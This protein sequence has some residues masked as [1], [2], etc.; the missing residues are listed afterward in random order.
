MGEYVNVL[1]GMMLIYHQRERNEAEETPV[2]WF[3]DSHPEDNK[4]QVKAELITRVHISTFSSVY[5]ETYQVGWTTIKI[6]GTCETTHAIAILAKPELHTTLGPLFM[7][8][9]EENSTQTSMRGY[10]PYP[11]WSNQEYS[12]QRLR[13]MMRQQKG[14]LQDRTSVTLLGIPA[15]SN[16][17]TMTPPTSYLE[18]EDEMTNLRSMVEIIY[19]ATVRV[20][21]QVKSSP[22]YKI[23]Q[24][25]SG[26]WRLIST[27]QHAE[28]LLEWAG[29][30]VTLLLPIY[31]VEVMGMK[32]PTISMD[33]MIAMEHASATQ[34]VQNAPRLESPQ[35]PMTQTD[36]R[37]LVDQE[38][39]EE[40]ERGRANTNMGDQWDSHEANEDRG[41]TA[42]CTQ[43][44]LP[45]PDNYVQGMAMEPPEEEQQTRWWP[46]EAHCR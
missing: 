38:Q 14:I 32:T 28:A 23:I 11:V 27:K 33:G 20:K 16:L 12:T 36:T 5:P 19:I 37:E 18:E 17:F 6:K 45:S 46:Y 39:R 13:A 26:L 7:A 2:V 1:Q 41:D 34:Q 9:A 31:I 4:Q 24:E 3:R 10:T 43:G 40:E 29:K 21:G 44:G 8:I 25:E 30:V 42:Y 22:V 35:K 15:G